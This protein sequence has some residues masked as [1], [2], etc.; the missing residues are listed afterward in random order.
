MEFSYTPRLLAPL[1]QMS[2]DAIMDGVVNAGH[3]VGSRRRTDFVRRRSTE[4]G[5]VVSRW[6]QVEIQ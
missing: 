5:R 6:N 4:P 1:T 3:V 2:T